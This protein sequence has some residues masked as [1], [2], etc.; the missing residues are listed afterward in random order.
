MDVAGKIID[1]RSNEY[2]V[3]KP[4]NAFSKRKQAKC[5]KETLKKK[6][7]IFCCCSEPPTSPHKPT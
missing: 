3:G 1:T 2:T 4:G 6:F 7:V 5:T